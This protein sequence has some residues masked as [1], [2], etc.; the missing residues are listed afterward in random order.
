MIIEFLIDFNIDILIITETWISYKDCPLLSSLNIDPY[1]FSHLPRSLGTRGGGLGILYKSS[2]HISPLI[3]HRHVYCE[4]FSC[5]VNS[6]RSRTF[7]ISVFYRTHSYLITHFSMN[8]I[9]HF[10]IFITHPYNSNI[11]LRY[12]NMPNNVLSKYSTRLTN[13][14]NSSNYSHFVNFP[15]HELGSLPISRSSRHLNYISISQFLTDLNMLPTHDAQSLY[16]SLLYILDIHAPVIN[17]TTISRYNR[18]TYIM[19]HY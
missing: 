8:L 14:L 1:S 18:F 9:S 4:G 7:N 5:S 11:I 12:F 16:N 6:P 10:N 19:V 2:L 15:T 13:I 3:D 17:K